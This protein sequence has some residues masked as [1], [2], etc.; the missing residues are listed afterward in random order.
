MAPTTPPID[1]TPDFVKSLPVDVAHDENT[2]IAFEMNGDAAAALERLS[3]A[4][5]R[6]RLDRHVLGEAGGEHQGASRRP[7]RTSG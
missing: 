1:K 5:H 2:L 6:A 3:G 4:A 7:R